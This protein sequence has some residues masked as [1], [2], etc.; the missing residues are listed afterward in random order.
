LQ[1]KN[2]KIKFFFEYFLASLRLAKGEI[3]LMVTQK[4]VKVR[5][6]KEERRHFAE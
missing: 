6:V 4:H 1:F 5:A 2:G 3:N